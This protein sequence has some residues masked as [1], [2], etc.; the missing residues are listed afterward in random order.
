[1][2][3][4]QEHLKFNPISS[5]LS[6]NN[7]AIEYFV[8]RHLLEEKVRP[9]DYI[10]E[11][12]EV[13]KIIKKQRSDGAWESPNRNKYKY[14]DVNYSLIETWKQFRFLT[15]KYEMY[16]THPGIE[17]AAE[18]IFSCQ[19]EDG[20]IRGMLANQYAMYY[21]GA[22]MSLL[23]KAGYGDD[24]RVEKGFKWLLDARQDDGGWVATPGIAADISW[25]QG[26]DLSTQNVRTIKEWDRSKPFSHLATGMIVRAFAAH[27]KYRKSSAAL[28]AARLL[29]S[30]FFKPES[31]AYKSKS[32]KHEDYWLVFQFPYWWNNLVAALD[33]ISMIG[34]SKEDE[35]IK[36]ALNW[37]INH[38]EDNGLWKISYSKIHKNT[39]TKRTKE[40]QLWI[41]LVIC[42]VLKRL[43]EKG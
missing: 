6:S 3:D 17:K 12:P 43:Y 24:S 37:L 26:C 7:E 41:T 20:D 30:R 9:I 16:K 18:F 39:E 19:T 10:W 11:L 38:Q 14:P 21:T 36:N 5:L 22:I 23:I 35:D 8:R 25:A 4:W 2:K 1:M 27:K 34:I 28:A 32:Y 15:E 29:K 13:K 33:S 42:R 31:D 40:A